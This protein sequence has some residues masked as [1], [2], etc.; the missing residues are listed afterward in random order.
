[1]TTSRALRLIRD[2]ATDYET[3]RALL[4]AWDVDERTTGGAPRDIGSGTLLGMS[5]KLV[6]TRRRVRRSGARLSPWIQGAPYLW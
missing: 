4:K 2:E 1:M 6:A 3:R 5:G